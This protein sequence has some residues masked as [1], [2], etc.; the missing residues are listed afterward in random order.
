M[1]LCSKQ[2]EAKSHQTRHIG[3]L[4]NLANSKVMVDFM[5]ELFCT[6]QDIFPKYT[7]GL[8]QGQMN[9]E[10]FANFCRDYDVFP[11][12][13]SKPAL[14]RIFHTLALMKEV[15]KP[16]KALKNTKRML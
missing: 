15:L 14:Y 7:G 4:I 16:D 1:P 13:C 12:F 9:F 3:K 8:K 10:Q 5:S 6:M 11:R 2:A